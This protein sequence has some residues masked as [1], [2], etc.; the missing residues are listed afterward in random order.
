MC[1]DLLVYDVYYVFYKSYFT[2]LSHVMFLW[3][4]LELHV[5]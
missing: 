4:L 5:L 3:L 1:H 2:D